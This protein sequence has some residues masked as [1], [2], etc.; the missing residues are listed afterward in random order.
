MVAASAL[1]LPRSTAER[2]LTDPAGPVTGVRAE[3]AC[4]P[5]ARRAAVAARIV[6][7]FVTA[8]PFRVRSGADGVSQCPVEV[9]SSRGPPGFRA[10]GL[11]WTA[12][13]R[14]FRAHEDQ[15]PPPPP[16]LR[17]L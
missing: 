15:A 14:R 3:A 7:V 11:G 12:P 10:I 6:R 8:S 4:A 1:T 13:G 5:T 2:S 9:R 16:P 17:K